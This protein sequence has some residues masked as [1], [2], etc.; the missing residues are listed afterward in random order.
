MAPAAALVTVG[1]TCTAR[2][3]GRTT[4]VAPAH[5]AERSSAPRLPGSVTPSTATRNGGRAAARRRQVVEDRPPAAGR[6][7]RARPAG[8][9]SGPRRRTSPRPTSRTG[10]RSASAS[11]TM[12]SRIGDGSASA[13][14]QHLAHVAAPRQQQLADGLAALHLV[15]AHALAAHRGARRPPGARAPADLARGSA[16]GGPT[17]ASRRSATRCRGAARD[18]LPVARLAAT[19]AAGLAHVD[20]GVTSA[21]AKQAIPSWRPERAETLGALALHR[22]RRTDGVGEEA[23]HLRAAWR[24][25]RR[26]EHHRAVDVAS[27]PSRGAHR[28][29]L[30]GA[31]APCCRRLRAPGRCRGSAARCRR[32]R[33]RRAASRRRRARRR[34]R[35]CGRPGRARRRRRRRRARGGAGR[36][37]R[38]GGR[39]SPGRPSPAQQ[40]RQGEVD[41]R[42]DLHVR[43]VA[44]HD[45]HPAT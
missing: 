39:R 24:Q 28:R 41:G 27:L 37:R 29:P 10:T 9:R 34:R 1:V 40:V 42:G 3:R 31:A 30:P 44:V 17:L 38:T 7:W 32:G 16:R 18:A 14:S 11:S 22:D 19:A 5:S 21:T 20:P 6:P 26:L 13:S 36:R 2:C 12:S 8:P 15:A 45:H 4:P 23:L 25:L 35:R 43:G 33:R